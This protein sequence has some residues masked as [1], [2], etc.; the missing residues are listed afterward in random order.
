MVALQADP[1]GELRRQRESMVAD[2]IARPLDGRPAV[3]DP[4]VLAAMRNV[5][6]HRFVDEQTEH[7]AYIDRP[8]PIG[9]RQ[10]IS[11]PYIVA[12]MTELLEVQSGH[13]VLEIGTGCG[14]QSAVLS[15]LARHVYTFEIV[16]AL[17]D[18]ATATLAELGYDNVTVR[19]GDGYTGWPDA[20]PF[21]RII[22]TAAPDHIPQP[23][24]DQLKPGGR[25]VLPVG[26]VWR[27]Q[28]LTLV[29][30]DASGDVQQRTIMAV[31]FVPLTRR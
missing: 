13:D 10:T 26:K 22:L 28:Q 11:Q 12:F 4:R 29:T 15:E 24:I 21:D 23:L 16:E 3:Q 27:S 25:M 7:L 20:A 1:A 31:G 6:R 18:R 17:A 19:F 2:Q 9:H 5:P 8:L 14:Y 30:R